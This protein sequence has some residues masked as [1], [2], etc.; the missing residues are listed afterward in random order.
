MDIHK[1]A[2]SCPASR[3]LLVRR[4]LEQ[5]WSVGEA[6]GAAGLSKRT[7][8][9]WLKRYRA[10]GP[11]DLADRSSRPRRSPGRAPLHRFFI[12]SRLSPASGE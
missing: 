11:S 9:K 8:Y 5:G 10:E 4:V 6:A 12:R 7:A 3:E 1:N 2:R